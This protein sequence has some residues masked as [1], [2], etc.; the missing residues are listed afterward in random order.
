[1]DN[2]LIYTVLGICLG[3]I[4]AIAATGLVVTY[5]TSGIFNFAHGAIGMLSAIFYWQ[6]RFGWHW[7]GPIAVAVTIL[8]FAPLVGAL[9]EFLIMRGL[10]GTSEVTQIVVPVAV[11]LAVNGAATWI[12]FRTGEDLYLPTRFFGETKTID[13][14]GQ[15]VYWHQVVAVV[16]AVLVA[17]GMYIL[18]YRT[19]IGVTMRATVDDRNLLMMNGGRPDRMSLASWA[20][21]AALAGLA[22]VLLAPSLG[23]LQV[24]ALTLLVFD[25]YPAAIVGRLK[26][27][28]LTYLG[29]LGL[30]LA[31]NYWTWV[32]DVGARWPAFRN[33][34]DALPAILLF[35]ALL[36]LPQERL[37]GATITRTRERFTVPSLGQSVV[38]GVIMMVVVA[39]LQ[40]IMANSAVI[41]LSNGIA[42]GLMALPLVLL[43]GYGGQVN[44]APYAFAGIAVI[45]AYQ[46]DVGP[47]GL[48][49]QESMSV[50]AIVLAVA[51]CAVVGGLIAFPALRLRGLYLGLATFAFAIIVDKLVIRQ[52]DPL[53]PEILGL[54][55]VNLFTNGTFTVPRPNWFG[56]NFFASQRN[57]L[58]LLTVVFVLI[59]LGLIT[60]RRSAFGRT[61]V[62]MKD[63]PAACAT[64][65]LNIVRTKLAVF[66]IASGLA[67][68]GGLLWT[69]Q[70]RT[71]NANG[72]FDP[73]LGLALFLIAVVGGI[74]YVSGAL[75]AGLFIAVL[76]SII[77]DVFEKLGEDY[78]SLQWL[79]VD[80][81]GNFAKF[82]GVAIAGIGLGRHPSGVA[83]QLMDGYRPLRKAP[84][85]VAIWVGSVVVLWFLAWQEVIGNWTFTLILA[86][87]FLVVPG[88]IMRWVHPAR[89]HHE[90]L[91]LSGPDLD[92]AGLDEPLTPTDRDRFDAALGLESL[93]LRTGVS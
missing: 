34:G 36:I 32:S 37:R 78:P 58:M 55:E 92:R 82:L 42:L 60:L 18:L 2:F 64:L 40:A 90:V 53:R 5:S 47:T 31:V 24:I 81:L 17:I 12:W 86:A 11:L 68:L 83:Q 88:R 62:A 39:G 80:T 74:G 76:G 46:F 50:A 21:G 26:S 93:D 51:V 57:M 56:V 43:T 35:V 65:G 33:V 61:I 52:Q 54:D 16:L 4:Y 75:L 89:F 84:G 27:V 67:G 6:V 59:G 25:A 70:Q 3:S 38:W 79:F 72:T 48:A 87:S 44:F 22:G 19:R 85:A 28:P 69:S 29:A 63:S 13:V 15:V 30:G 41:Q 77:P 23:A 1:M 91:H 73:F 45:V 9:I 7:A 71:V 66:T 8:V 14:L 20:I 10:Q 49:R